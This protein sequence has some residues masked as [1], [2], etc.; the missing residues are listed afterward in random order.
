MPVLVTHN[1]FDGITCAVLFKATWPDGKVYITNYDEV[2]R[3]IREACKEPGILFITD[4]S[5]QS[6]DVARLL[7][8]RGRVQLFDHH[9]TAL[10]LSIYPYACI[11][12]EMCGARLFYEFHRPACPVMDDYA[13]LVWHANDYDL[14]RHESP[15]SAVLNRLLHVLG[16]EKFIERFLQNP[17]VKLT[18]QEQYLMDIEAGREQRYIDEAVKTAVV[19]N[20]LTPSCAIVFAEQYI[21]QVGH[22]LLETYPVDVAV[23]VNVQK[24]TVSL[25]SR[26]KGVDVSEIA[27]ALGGGGHPTAAGFMLPRNKFRDDI[28][29]MLLRGI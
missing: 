23:I 28:A 15:H 1:D 27:K 6:E 13:E 24:N 7:A 25:R 19:Y 18:G 14:W 12:T 4:I 8:A 20:S 3:V 10:W 17:T 11:D 29:A 9:K 26:D 5:P 22:K 2:D 21:S 16:H